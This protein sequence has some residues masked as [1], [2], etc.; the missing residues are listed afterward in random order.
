MENILDIIKISAIHPNLLILKDVLDIIGKVSGIV[1]FVFVLCGIIF[2]SQI[3]L[4]FASLFIITGIV[5]AT[6]AIG[7]W[8]LTIAFIFFMVFYK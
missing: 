8:Y 6:L 3:I 4:S 1:A 7:Q 5:L 2:K